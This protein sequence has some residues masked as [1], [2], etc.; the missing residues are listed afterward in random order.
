MTF[1]SENGLIK[2][3]N[4]PI[5]FVDGILNVPLGH[6]EWG[7]YPTMAELR[8]TIYRTRIKRSRIHPLICA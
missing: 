5:D 2:L 1:K 3:I 4:K 7:Q 6:V 8:D